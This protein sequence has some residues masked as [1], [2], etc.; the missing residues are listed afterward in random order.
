MKAKTSKA[1]KPLYLDR[2]KLDKVA[3]TYIETTTLSQLNADQLS[4][5]RRHLDEQYACDK[6]V[7]AAK[8]EAYRSMRDVLT[9]RIAKLRRGEK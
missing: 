9:K 2:K 7:F 5:E 4:V 6:L 1:K 3:N 8:K